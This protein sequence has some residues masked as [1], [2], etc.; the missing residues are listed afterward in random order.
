MN[1]FLYSSVPWNIKSYIRRREGGSI[2]VDDVSPMNI[3]AYTHRF[4]VTDEYIPIFLGTLE[5]KELYSSALRSLVVLSVNRGIYAIFYGDT[6]IF[7]DC[8]R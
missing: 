5:Y 8:N 1:I 6:A 3:L 7:I 2:F 4:H